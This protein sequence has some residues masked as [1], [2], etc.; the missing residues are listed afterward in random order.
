VHGVPLR[1]SFRSLAARALRPLLTALDRR[2]E[3]LAARL[4]LHTMN[5]ADVQRREIA[6]LDDRLRYDVAVM[7]E[8]LVGMERMARHVGEALEVAAR[9]A[10][11]SAPT[12]PGGRAFVVALPGETLDLPGG[13][14]LVL[15]LAPGGDGSWQT[16]TD[17]VAAAGRSTL[18][19]VELAEDQG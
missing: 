4:E 12:S 8:H 6:G 18:R 16:V 7:S 9:P 2:L 13:A 17:P 11:A 5:L 3:Q 1:S 15:S 14:S 10:P 19:I